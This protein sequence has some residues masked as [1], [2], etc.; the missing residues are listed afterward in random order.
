MAQTEFVES[1]RTTETTTSITQ[2]RTYTVDSQDPWDALADTDVPQIG[3][4]H[5]I[6][7]D[8]FVVER[9]AETISP[10][11]AR[12]TVVYSREYYQ[13]GDINQEETEIDIG[14]EQERVYFENQHKAG[15]PMTQIVDPLS[16]EYGVNIYRPLAVL[17]FVQYKSFFNW[18]QYAD[19]TG[20]I[21]DG[22][23]RG[24]PPRTVRFDGAIGRRIGTEKW[25]I[26]L[27][28]CYNPRGINPAFYDIEEKSEVLPGGTEE[29]YWKEVRLDT[30][31]H[32]IMIEKFVYPEEN[33]TAI[34]GS[35]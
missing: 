11:L 24:M 29:R 3:D 18:A 25:Q 34:F 23:W 4:R 17:S 10:E 19:V 8:M 21:N 30:F 13:T 20:T 5:P 28:F 12:V 33:F 9:S 2:E 15:E 6:R 14:A 16:G 26:S 35:G 31:G 32:P 7:T 27:R 1:R 22:W